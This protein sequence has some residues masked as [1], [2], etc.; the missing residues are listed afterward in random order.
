M[1]QIINL[2]FAYS[3]EF[4]LFHQ[5][6]LNLAR[7]RHGLVGP[8]AA[9]KSTLLALI[10]GQLAPTA[11]S[12]FY[13]TSDLQSVSQL[14]TLI[15][16]ETTDLELAGRG[17]GLAA[18][19]AAIHELNGRYEVRSE[20]NKGFRLQISHPSGHKDGRGAVKNFHSCD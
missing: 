5:L 6:H 1:L 18:V 2:S 11:A 8:S 19:A 9:G 20:K 12:I 10:A 13:E 3:D 17:M 7:A 14:D 4:S 15:C 16:A